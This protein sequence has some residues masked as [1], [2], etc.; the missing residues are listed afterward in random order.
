MND[1]IEN[2]FREGLPPTDT[3]V[4]DGWMKSGGGE[5]GLIEFLVDG[6]LLLLVSLFYVEF[7]LLLI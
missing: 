5:G 3:D 6:I 1:A 4:V 7:C 2:K